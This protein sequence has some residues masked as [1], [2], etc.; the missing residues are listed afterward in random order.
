MTGTYSGT[1]LNNDIGIICPE[2]FKKR[3][4]FVYNNYKPNK[5]DREILELAYS[6]C[7]I[8]NKREEKRS[9]R[10]EQY[11]VTYFYSF[12]Y[13]VEPGRNSFPERKIIIAFNRE[14]SVIMAKAQFVDSDISYAQPN[15]ELTNTWNNQA[16]TKINVDFANS[17]IEGVDK[18][19]YGSQLM[20]LLLSTC[21]TGA[22]LHDRTIFATDSNHANTLQEIF[23]TLRLHKITG[24]MKQMNTFSTS[25]LAAVTV[26][27]CKFITS[28]Q[29]SDT[30]YNSF[31]KDS[32][33]HNEMG[34]YTALLLLK[35]T[36]QKQNDKDSD[37]KTKDGFKR[38]S[39]KEELLKD[40]LSATLS[41]VV[42][43]ENQ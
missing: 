20:Q 6:L 10:K 16:Y 23:S 38:F 37:D 31:L 5:S 29:E 43:E 34:N 33:K 13:T 1:S 3:R 36:M 9:E 25:L 28:K 22:T 30:V 42:S 40:R 15:R 39:G 4:V 8:L 32:F 17:E 18:V 2:R 19:S 26:T 21:L 11:K 41:N 35:V 7:D 27:D 24:N 12:C 14:I